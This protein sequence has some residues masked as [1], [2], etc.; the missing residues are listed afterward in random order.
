[1]R[2]PFIALC[3]IAAISSCSVQ[4]QPIAGTELRARAPPDPTEPR[5][6][7]ASETSRDRPAK[8]QKKVSASHGQDIQ[9]VQRKADRRVARAKARE[10]AAVHWSY[11]DDV[12]R[13]ST[14]LTATNPVLTST[15]SPV[16]ASGTSLRSKAR[17]Q[18]TIRQF[19]TTP[20]LTLRKSVSP[21]SSGFLSGYSASGSEAGKPRNKGTATTS[22]S[23]L[24]TSTSAGELAHDAESAW[25]K[26]MGHVLL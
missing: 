18:H 8:I 4:G 12:D 17:W 24:S 21:S 14:S 15:T 10:A 5:K 25:K 9:A 23:S 13:A 26:G 20:H 1:M 22:T 7:S 2:A 11:L 6:S 16:R 19:K 3:L